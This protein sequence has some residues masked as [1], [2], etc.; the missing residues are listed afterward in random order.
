MNASPFPSLPRSRPIIG[1]LLL[2]LLV[3]LCVLRSWIGTRLDSLT[4]DEPWHIVAGTAYA[5]TGD[6]HLN[7]E[8]P[9][10]V[11]LWVGHAMPDDFT[12]RPAK[13][14]NEKAQ[15][16]TW[17]EE[18]MFKDNDA[19][20]AQQYS[21]AAMWTLNGLLLLALGLLLW[22]ACG[23]VWAAGALSFLTLEP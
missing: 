2:L 12:L 20:R 3:A 18:T 9:P 19:L 16:R 21:R 4:V 6:F 10:L 5:R 23:W 8:H 17:V 1:F 7:P 11:K 14:L 13:V 22:C 15:E